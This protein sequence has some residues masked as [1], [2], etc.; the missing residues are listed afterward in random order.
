[1]LLNKQPAASWQLAASICWCLLL[2]GQV[3]M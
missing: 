1:M 2:F 3:R